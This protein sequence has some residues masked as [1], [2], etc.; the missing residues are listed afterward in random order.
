MRV[1]FNSNVGFI[2]DGSITL[3]EV[4]TTVAVIR[5]NLQQPVR[6]MTTT[7]NNMSACSP[8]RSNGLVLETF[9]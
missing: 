6:K 3:L 8:I 9:M 5:N 2:N 1:I 7:I 4:V